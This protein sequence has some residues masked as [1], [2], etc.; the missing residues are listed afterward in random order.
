MSASVSLVLLAD[1]TVMEL[2][3]DKGPVQRLSEPG[4]NFL[5]EHGFSVLVEAAHGRRVLFDAGATRLVVPHNLELLGLDIARDIDVAVISHGHSDH[6]GCVSELRCPVFVHP[7]APGPRFLLREG[8]V[9]FDLTARELLFLGD[10]QRF[11]AEPTEVAPGIWTTGEIARENQWEAPRGFVRIRQQALEDDQVEDDQGLV[12][13]TGAGL[14]ILLGCGHA[15]LVNTVQHA[16]RVTGVDRVHA[17][18]GGF[19]LIDADEDKLQRTIA[20][21]QDIDPDILAPTHCTG[22]HAIAALSSA[23]AAKFVYLTGGHRL[24]VG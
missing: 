9:R 4:R 24:L 6:T 20:A 19:H 7:D 11:T 18:V 23:F 8:Q 15:G 3:P 2:I 17:V 21:L 16:R 22:F 1:N 12:L 10:R 14:V 13:I 5:A